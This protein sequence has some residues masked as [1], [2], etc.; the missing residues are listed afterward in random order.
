MYSPSRLTVARKRSGLTMTALAATIGMS[1]RSI[2]AYE[3]GLEPPSEVLDRIA[4]T[5]GFPVSFFSGVELDIPLASAV[6][7]RALSKMSAIERDRALSQGALALELNSWIEQRFDLPTSQL[8]DLSQESDPEAAATSLRQQ[9]GLGEAPVKN[10]IHLLEAKGV[11]VYSLAV[12][13][14]NVDAY[15]CWHDETP[16]MF[17][18]TRKSA[19]R[20][21]F[22]AAHELGHLVLHRHAPKEDTRLA[23]VDANRFASSFLM[24]RAG[25][26]ARAPIFVT[27]Q[28]LI[29]RK[30]FWIVSVA[31]LNHRLHELEITN[32]WQHRHLSAEI[33]KRGFRTDEPN[34]APRE[35]SQ[36][37][38]KVLTALRNDGLSQ[39]DIADCLDY[40]LFELEQ[41]IF[42]LTMISL[43]GSAKNR[44]SRTGSG[45]DLKLVR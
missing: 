1:P 4:R 42:G 5:L 21:R 20:S 3:A 6:S 30:K 8:P 14:L 38:A 35:S 44:L 23:E 22:D 2:S 24:P 34:P 7:F 36:L 9:W 28:N 31:A 13:S 11:R 27:V 26:I 17:L 41:L 18:N 10:M 40:P 32:A 45:A 19:E 33:S 16:M 15:S 29:E 25:T 12:D 37:L 39:R 43:E